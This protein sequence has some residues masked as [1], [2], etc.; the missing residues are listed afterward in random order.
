MVG[1][2][3]NLNIL[4]SELWNVGV[5]IVKTTEFVQGKTSRWGLA[6]SFTPAS[7][8]M[9]SSHR[10]EK[11]NVSFML[12]VCIQIMHI[13]YSELMLFYAAYVVISYTNMTSDGVAC[14]LCRAFNVNVVPFTCCILWNPFLLIVGPPVN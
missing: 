8:K 1:R 11:N 14:C 2:K 10:M 5:S 7:R 13:S 12:E 3:L 4:V 9:I 6:W